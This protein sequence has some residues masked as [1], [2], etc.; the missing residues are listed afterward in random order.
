MFAGLAIRIIGGQPVIIFGDETRRRDFIHINDITEFN[1]ML[2]ESGHLYDNETFNLGTG[3]STSLI[4]IAEMISHY[5]N[6]PLDVL[7]YPEINGEAH[8]IVANMEY[9]TNSTGFFP[10]HTMYDMVKSSVDFCL[11]EIELGNINVGGFMNSIDVS[12]V[13]IGV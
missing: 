13:K 5:L 10:K 6:E 1:V 2:I 9:T 4:D 7:Y 11:K 3:T 8:T 12:S